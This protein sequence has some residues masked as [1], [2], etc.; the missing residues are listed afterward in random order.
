MLL[1]HGYQ[2]DLPLKQG[3]ELL[4]YLKRYPRMGPISSLEKE[5]VLKYKEHLKVRCCCCDC[6]STLVCFVDSQCP[7]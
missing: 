7:R 6:T 1:A 5:C 2:G 4:E 3:L